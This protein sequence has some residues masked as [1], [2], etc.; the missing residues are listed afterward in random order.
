M[1]FQPFM[2]VLDHLNTC[3][4]EF[5][6]MIQ[7][8][9]PEHIVHAVVIATPGVSAWLVFCVLHHLPDKFSYSIDSEKFGSNFGW[10]IASYTYKNIKNNY[11]EL[12]DENLLS[13]LGWDKMAANP[14][15][16]FEIYV[17]VW[18]L[19]YLIEFSLKFVPR[20]AINN[21]INQCWLR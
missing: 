18:N 15:T 17:F 13:H 5:V 2:N 8:L 16:I 4:A 7:H 12:C 3:L 6:K 11:V 1:T 21:M 10:E 19:A 9:Y 20:G 14:Q